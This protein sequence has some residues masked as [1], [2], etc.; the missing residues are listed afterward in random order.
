[1]QVGNGSL[2]WDIQELISDCRNCGKEVC[3]NWCVDMVSLQVRDVVNRAKQSPE[4]VG[5]D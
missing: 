1:M 5:C 3:P 4:Y 2:Y